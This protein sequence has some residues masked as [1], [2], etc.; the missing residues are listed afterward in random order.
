MFVFAFLRVEL[1]FKHIISATLKISLHHAL[2]KHIHHRI[3]RLL[4]E[5]FHEKH[6]KISKANIVPH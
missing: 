5:D 1:Y 6:N 3:M 4:W 2:L